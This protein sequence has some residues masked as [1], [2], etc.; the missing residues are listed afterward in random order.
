MK[1]HIPNTLTCCNLLSGCVATYFALQANFDLAFLFV[2]IGAVFDFFDG[3]AARLLHVTS[4]I[5][6]EL[7]SLADDITFGFAPA[8]TLFAMLSKLL[9]PANLPAEFPFTDSPILQYVPFIAFLVAAFSALRLA[10]F[11][12]DERQTTSFIG[13]PTPANALF[14]CSLAAALDHS[15]WLTG[16][17]WL[18]VVL[19]AGVLLSCWLLV[20]EIPMFSL[21]FKNYGWR[22]NEIRYAFI[23]CAAV[24]LCS[25]EWFGFSA[26]IVL[27]IF[28]SVMNNIIG[29]RIV[30]V[31]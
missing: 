13:L 23:L 27:Y 5:G 7:D 30:S 9:S 17:P 2:I 6:K 28:S 25:L 3:F 14:W 22:G 11:N 26:V 18:A 29:T 4:A 12:L 10:K 20:S 31:E 24:L 1:K 15:A 16:E 19:I 21:K 8:A